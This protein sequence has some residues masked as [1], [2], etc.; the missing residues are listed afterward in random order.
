MSTTFLYRLHNHL[1]ILAKKSRKSNSIALPQTW[2]HE[3]LQVWASSWQVTSMRLINTATVQPCSN[4]CAAVPSRVLHK[5]TE[6]SFSLHSCFSY[7]HRP[8]PL[9][10][11]SIR[12]STTRAGIQF[13]GPGRGPINVSH[14][15]GQISDKAV[16]QH[17]PQSGCPSVYSLPPLYLLDRK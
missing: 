9:P 14:T 11:S 10:H 17:P 7:Q 15:S 8:Y 5:Q 13:E 4:L 6:Y 12:S 16:E 1:Q 2:L 3:D